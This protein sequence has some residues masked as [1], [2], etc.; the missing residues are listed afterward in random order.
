[1][2]VMGERTRTV[3]LRD[4]TLR[5]GLDTPNVDFSLEQRVKIA[6]HLDQANVPELEVVAPGH[7]L[8]DLQCVKRLNEEGLQSK[9][10]GLIYAYVPDCQEQIEEA[11][12]HLHRFDMLMPL[13]PKRK[14]YERDEKMRLLLEMLSYA[15]RYHADVGVGFPHATQVGVDVVLE[16][17]EAAVRSGAKRITVYDTNGSADPFAVCDLIKRL[18]SE[19]NVPL[20]FHG[21][22]D[23]GLATGNALGAVYAGAD[24]L[25]VTMNGLGDRAGNASLEQ[26]VLGLYLRG[27]STGVKLDKLRSLSKM[28]EEES[29][30][31]VSKLAPVVGEYIFCHKSPSH[32]EHPEIFEAFNPMLSDSDRSISQS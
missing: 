6:K 3:I 8:K 24:G 19:L 28:V 31:Q 7:V 10:S 16:L 21:H 32:L 15:L 18:K 12:R 9:T 23:L 1:M 27:F 25:D 4:V 2:I 14:P 11:A 29:G 5:E 13:S 26:V 20:F 30:V 17:G 22:N